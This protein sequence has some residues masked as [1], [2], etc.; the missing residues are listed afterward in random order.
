MDRL[1]YVE[2]DYDGLYGKYWSELGQVR[3]DRAHFLAA[4]EEYAL[5]C[6]T[7]GSDVSPELYGHKNLGSF[8]EPARD[9]RELE[10]FEAAQAAGLPMT[11]ICRGSQFLNVMC[12]GTMVQNM[13]GHGGG[14]H[15][16]MSFNG[17]EMEVTS[18]HHQ[19]NVL[20]KGGLL[21][22]WAKEVASDSLTYDGDLVNIARHAGNTLPEHGD[23]CLVTEAFAYPEKNIFAV[24]HHP[25]WQDID[26]R[27]AQWTLEQTRAFCFGEFEKA[28]GKPSEFPFP[29]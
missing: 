9:A 23:E 17:E 13:S 12:G 18:S 8:N 5:V 6:F 11:G 7:G 27:A 24:Q 14:N 26:C 29:N 1:I 4:P 2:Y 25:E 22:G 10:V 20:G 3:K 28:A 21:L 15:T 16:Q 19:M